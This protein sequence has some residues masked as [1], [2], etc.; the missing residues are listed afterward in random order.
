MSTAV[1]YTCCACGGMIDSAVMWVGEKPMHTLCAFKSTYP[2]A[3]TPARDMYVPP[4]ITEDRVREIVR[5][6][7]LKA[8]TK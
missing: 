3:L 5:E 8:F 4:S 7:I 1:P 6:E 2:P